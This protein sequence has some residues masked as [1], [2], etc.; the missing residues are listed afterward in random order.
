MNYGE[1]FQTIRKNKGLTLNEVSGT[2]ISTAQLSRFENGKTMLTVDQFF[3]CLEKMNTTIEEFQ[4]MQKHTWRET[5]GE[6]VLEIET[7]ANKGDI[8][9]LLSASKNYFSKSQKQYDW[10]YFFGCFFENIAIF[11]EKETRSQLRYVEE[12]THFF[13]KSEQWGEMELRVFGMFLFVFDGETTNYLLQIAL[14][15]GKFYQALSK[16]RRLFYCLLNNCFS[17][18]IFHKKFEDARKVLQLLEQETNEKNDLLFPQINFLFN[19]GIISFVDGDVE[20][21]T[22]YCNQAISICHIFH[23]KQQ[24]AIFSRRL[25]MWHTEQDKEEFAELVLELSYLLD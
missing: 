3:I 9:G 18:F 7:L 6:A 20:K 12:L 14:K 4:F 2:T 10:D 1:T 21:A 5:Y 25:N 24:A 11:H 8:S 17:V 19:K 16:D 23:Q 15:R 22:T 13:L